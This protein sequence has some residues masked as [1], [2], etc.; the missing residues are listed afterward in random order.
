MDKIDLKLLYSLLIESFKHAYDLKDKIIENDCLSSKF[1]FEF[2]NRIKEKFFKEDT[3]NIQNV[4]D[5]GKRSPGE[6]L[7]DT[8]IV[9]RKE[10]YS[11]YKT[12]KRFFVNVEI[13]L[14][15]ESEFGTSIGEFAQDFGKIICAKSLKKI[16]INGLNQKYERKRYIE[17]R[18]NLINKKFKEDINNLILVF[19]PSTKG[20]LWRK[21]GFDE[22][23][24]WIE[25]YYK[26]S[27]DKELTKFNI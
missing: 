11:L 26:E 9:R 8:C 4:D 6:W 12:E 13:L 17:E 18:V 22:L 21:N 7:Y 19:F 2:S 27:T 25:I 10:I 15:L 24:S 14:A 3:L 20:N 23:K 16:Y 1:I 5:N